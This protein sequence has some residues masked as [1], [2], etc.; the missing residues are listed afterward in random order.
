MSPRRIPP[1]GLRRPAGTPT[2]QESALLRA[3]RRYAETEAMRVLVAVLALA[4]V[5]VLAVLAWLRLF[6]T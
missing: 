2:K 5:F 4:A 3:A 1:P 6:G